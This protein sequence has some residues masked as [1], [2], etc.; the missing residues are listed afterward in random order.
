[1]SCRSRGDRLIDHSVFE[2]IRCCGAN[3]RSELRFLQRG[4]VWDEGTFYV[5]TYVIEIRVS[6][7]LFEE[8]R[9]LVF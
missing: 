8:I 5:V 3:S 7:I 2:M 4:A 1:V 6:L 9:V